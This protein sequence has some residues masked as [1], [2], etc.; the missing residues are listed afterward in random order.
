MQCSAADLYI[1]KM[2]RFERYMRCSAA[3]AAAAADRVQVRV[4]VRQHKL[5]CVSEARSMLQAKAANVT[6][7][8]HRGCS[9]V[10]L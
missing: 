5:S 3:A 7:Q 6:Q 10:T 1:S 2:N 8:C 9:A 4:Q